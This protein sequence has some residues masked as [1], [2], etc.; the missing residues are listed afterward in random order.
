V[1]LSPKLFFCFLSCVCLENAFGSGKQSLSDSDENSPEVVQI[2]PDGVDE[3]MQ[4]EESELKSE[5]DAH[6]KRALTHFFGFVEA[7]TEK[8]KQTACQLPTF[9]LF[10]SHFMDADSIRAVADSFKN[11]FELTGPRVTLEKPICT[12]AM[13]ELFFPN[14]RKIIEEFLKN[15]DLEW[16]S[17][18]RF[19]F[20][21]EAFAENS[22]R[23]WR[24]YQAFD[25]LFFAPEGQG[26]FD[27][28]LEEVGGDKS[29]IDPQVLKWIPLAD[30]KKIKNG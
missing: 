11:L 30:Y 14:S 26:V 1:N 7:M 15:A 13:F 9:Q 16:I 20:F 8:E 23:L 24:P 18:T 5:R 2:L 17:G 27:C 21:V 19:P 4:E 10:F 12:Y 25:A 22:R 28:F 29:K 3:V 6:K